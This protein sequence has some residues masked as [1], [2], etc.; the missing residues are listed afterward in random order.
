MLDISG[1]RNLF[2]S[3]FTLS[4]SQWD[5]A[6]QR[7]TTR[8]QQPPGGQSK[9]WCSPSTVSLSDLYVSLFRLG[10]W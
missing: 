4:G 3:S 2:D 9:G 10:L 5:D 6:N 1:V 7:K 8:V